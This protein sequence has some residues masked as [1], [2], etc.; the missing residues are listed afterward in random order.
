MKKVKIITIIL[1]IV[2]VSL[3]AFGGVY[4]QTQNRMEDKV[5][6]HPLPLPKREGRTNRPYDVPQ[7]RASNGF[8]R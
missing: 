1:A 8:I 3:V 2:L 7:C 5:K 6:T 4:I